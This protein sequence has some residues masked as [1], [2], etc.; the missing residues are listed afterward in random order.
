M[1]FSRHKNIRYFF[2]GLLTL[3]LM[4]ISVIPALAEY[5]TVTLSN[6]AGGAAQTYGSAGACPQGA[7][8]ATGNNFTSAPTSIYSLS[9]RIREWSTK[10]YNHILNEIESYRYWNT[11]SGTATV[12]WVGCNY[13]YVTTRHGWIPNPGAASTTRYTSAS[14]N[15]SSAT[16]WNGNASC[17]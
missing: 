2:V 10:D 16:C 12:P 5:I 3:L 13:V 6:G 11:N 8:Q 1:K 7:G 15:S 17:H 4:F 9:S 14:G